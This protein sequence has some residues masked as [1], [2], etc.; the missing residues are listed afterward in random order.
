[1]KQ[2]LFLLLAILTT[3]TASAQ[4]PAKDTAPLVYLGI[5]STL[6][7]IIPSPAA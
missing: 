1:M 3:F 7:T 2:P 4:Q 5:A 6:S